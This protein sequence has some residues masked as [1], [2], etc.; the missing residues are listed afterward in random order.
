[1]FVP[2]FDDSVWLHVIFRVVIQ[3][4]A[5]FVIFA[6]RVSLTHI[7]SRAVCCRLESI[8]SD[9]L[10]AAAGYVVNTTKMKMYI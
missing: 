2:G 4:S 5:S 1:M 3:Q 10:M 9:M 6:I 8:I 7:W